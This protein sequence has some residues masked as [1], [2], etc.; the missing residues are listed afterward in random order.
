[1]TARRRSKKNPGSLQE[2]CALSMAT[3][4]STHE[5]ILPRPP[6]T[7]NEEGGRSHRE[8]RYA[9]RWGRDTPR[10]ASLLTLLPEACAH[11]RQGVGLPRIHPR[12]YLGGVRRKGLMRKPRSNRAETSR[13]EQGQGVGLAHN[14]AYRKQPREA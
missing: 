6:A 2:T 4:G 5:E 3:A 7:L 8:A 13:L 10:K 14:R 11:A 9:A 1:M 12:G